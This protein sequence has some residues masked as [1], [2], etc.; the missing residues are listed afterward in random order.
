MGYPVQ[1]KE[2]FSKINVIISKEWWRQLGGD[3]AHQ[4]FDNVNIE[5]II[6]VIW[7]EIH[8]IHGKPLVHNDPHTEKNQYVIY[9]I[10][11][12]VSLENNVLTLF[13]WIFRIN[14]QS[15]GIIGIKGGKIKWY[16][17]EIITEMPNEQFIGQL[18]E[19]LCNDNLKT[20][21]NLRAILTTRF[22]YGLGLD[23]DWDRKRTSL[24]RREHFIHY[25]L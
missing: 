9:K 23:H 11:S 10:T 21:I 14:F 22:I 18:V 25:I 15:L 6:M 4:S 7:I 3:S 8:W 1:K 2:K 5:K 16:H 12:D 20:E 13:T 24:D 17:K 19:W